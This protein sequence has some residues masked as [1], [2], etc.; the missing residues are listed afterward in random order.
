MA[1]RDRPLSPRGQR[2]AALMAAELQRQGLHA[3]RILCSPARRTRETLAALLSG[4]GDE[5]RIAITA[6]LYEPPSGDYLSVIAARGT[7]AGTLLVIGHNP[8]I[9]ATALLLASGPTKLK[10]LVAAKLPTGALVGID[11]PS[12][13]WADLKPETGRITLF[14]KPSDLDSAGA[15]EDD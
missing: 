4:V 3:D 13:P 12:G 15:R 11:F 9:Q 14:L 7:D 10:S 1:D 2:D 8:A 6:G 5:T